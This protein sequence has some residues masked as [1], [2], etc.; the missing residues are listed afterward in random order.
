[1]KSREINE[2]KIIEALVKNSSA[3]LNETSKKKILNN[4]N[5]KLRNDYM[6]KYIF[7][8]VSFLTLVLVGLFV[9]NTYLN[10]PEPIVINEVVTQLK[11]QDNNT[12]D[13]AMKIAVDD[14][15]SFNAAQNVLSFDVLVPTVVKGGQL[16]QVQTARTFDGSKSDSIYTTFAVDGDMYFQLNEMKTDPENAYVPEDST[17]ITLKVN[18]KELEGYYVKYQ[19]TD[20]DPNSEMALYGGNSAKS[21]IGFYTNGVQFSI[22]EFGKLTQSDLVEIASSLK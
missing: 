2:N 21:E 4:I 17:K 14:H 5:I 11:P 15:T 20:I 6:K 19:E 9:F 22:Y 12:G 8:S 1:M 13:A 18:G 7:G 10:K 3:G 16:A